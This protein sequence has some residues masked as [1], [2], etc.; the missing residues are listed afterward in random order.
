MTE[1]EKIISL[2]RE[3]NVDSLKK[4]RYRMDIYELTGQAIVAFYKAAQA[5]AYENAAVLA[6]EWG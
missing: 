6:T 1:R 2:A 5:E 4:P 3:C